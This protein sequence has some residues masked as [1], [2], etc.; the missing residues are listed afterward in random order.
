LC[1]FC[2]KQFALIF[3]DTENSNLSPNYPNQFI[4]SSPSYFKKK[5]YKEPP[6]SARAV[7]ATITLSSNT[8]I[9]CI[10]SSVKEKEMAMMDI[11]KRQ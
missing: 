1:K 10:V 5:F 8:I 3:S 9:V 4:Y 7:Y 6:K 2:V 11:T